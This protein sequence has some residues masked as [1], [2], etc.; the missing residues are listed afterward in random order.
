MLFRLRA[1]PQLEEGVAALGR[2]DEDRPA[3]P[4]G[5]R[6][7]DDLRPHARV[8]VGVFVE[9]DTVEIDAA[10]RIGI[11]GAIEP[12]LPSVGI[13][14]AQLGFVRARP[15]RPHR[16]HGVA[17]IVPRH[18]LRLLEEGREIGE[19]RAYTQALGCRA[20]QV[21]HATVL[22]ARRCVT[23]QAE[24]SVLLWEVMN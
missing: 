8:H 20:L 16:R 18:R 12:H 6:R 15:D 11:V 5:Q 2:A 7:P 1:P 19:A 3:L 21:V 13:I 17:Q 14:D 22:P 10:Q 23:M 24:R 9:H 4:I